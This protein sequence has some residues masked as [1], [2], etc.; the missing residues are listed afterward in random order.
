MPAL[1]TPEA[2]FIL[3]ADELLVWAMKHQ[4]DPD[5]PNDLAEIRKK[6]LQLFEAD[7][8]HGIFYHAD[9]V[10]ADMVAR[11]TRDLRSEKGVLETIRA[12]MARIR[13]HEEHRCAVEELQALQRHL[14]LLE[15]L[16]ARLEELAAPLLEQRAAY[17]ACEGW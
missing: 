3:M 12:T 7:I 15:R 10:V 9:R 17:E 13:R 2:D 14:P 6:A 11:V 16:S 5:R 8:V 1:G 4:L